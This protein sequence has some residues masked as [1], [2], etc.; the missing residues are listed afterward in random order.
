MVNSNPKEKNEISLNP[1]LFLA[2]E[3]LDPIVVSGEIL[4]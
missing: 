2:L 4:D 1:H 3:R